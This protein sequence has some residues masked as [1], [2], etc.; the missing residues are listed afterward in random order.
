LLR[1]VYAEIGKDW[2]LIAQYIPSRTSEQVRSHAQKYL[3]RRLRRETEEREI[4]EAQ[5]IIEGGSN[6]RQTRTRQLAHSNS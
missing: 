4:R 3:S 6:Q 5:K 1:V 2:K